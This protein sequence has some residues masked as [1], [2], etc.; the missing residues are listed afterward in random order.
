MQGFIPQ[1]RYVSW[2][3]ADSRNLPSRH[4]GATSRRL[5]APV[6]ILRRDE[7]QPDPH[8]PLNATCPPACPPPVFSISTAGSLTLRAHVH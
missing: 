3:S 4:P 6:S 8:A 1:N 2:V 5:G 7:G